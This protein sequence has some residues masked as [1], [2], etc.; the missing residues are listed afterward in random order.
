MHINTC[1]K[2]KDADVLKILSDIG[3]SKEPELTAD[4]EELLARALDPEKDYLHRIQQL[5]NH[6]KDTQ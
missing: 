1:M 2:K 3:Y 4:Q 5:F 6:K